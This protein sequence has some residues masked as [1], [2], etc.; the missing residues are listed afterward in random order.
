MNYLFDVRLQA[1]I[2]I[3]APSELE[4]RKTLNTVLDCAS[5]NLGEVDG[6]PLVAEVS[7]CGDA[8]LVEVDGETVSTEK[9]AATDDCLWNKDVVRVYR[10]LAEVHAMAPLSQD[11]LGELC[12]TLD[13]NPTLLNRHGVR[14]K[15]AWAAH[16]KSLRRN[17]R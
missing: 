4:A 7:Q 11:Q 16:K 5:A 13:L 3:N 12:E 1:S 6:E 15:S 14:A 2:R 10:L 17:S 9:D 8:L